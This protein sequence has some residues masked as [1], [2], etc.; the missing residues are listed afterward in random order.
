MARCKASVIIGKI[1]MNVNGLKLGKRAVVLVGNPRKTYLAILAKCFPITRPKPG[2]H[3]SAVVDEQAKIHPTAHIDPRCVIGKCSIG[4]RSIVH[5]NVN[6][7]DGVRI[8]RNVIIYPGCAIGYDGFGHFENEKGELENFPQYGGVVIEDDVE[9]F[10]LTN[11]DRGTLDDT[12]IGAGTKIDH[13]CH[14]G[15]NVVI[16]KRCVITACTVIAGSATIGDHA[17][18]GINSSIRDWIAVGKNAFVGMGSVVTKDVP[19][20]A[21]VLGNPARPY[22]PKVKK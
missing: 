18:I 10:A 8:G 1:G 5:G 9:I 22:K 14:I 11:I 19:D 17:Y 7:N 16:G 15:H 3:P 6:I 2:I 12:I 20:N 13:H 4:A 21:V